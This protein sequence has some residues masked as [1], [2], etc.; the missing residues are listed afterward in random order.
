M[1]AKNRLMAIGAHTMNT[2][3]HDESKDRRPST[4]L[5]KQGVFD[6][7][8]SSFREWV[9]DSLG[10]RFRAEAGRYH[11]YV[12][13]GCPWAHRTLIVRALKGLERTIDITAVLKCNLR[14]LI[15]Y[16]NLFAD[17]R[18]F[19]QWPG[20]RLP[21][22][23]QAENTLSAAAPGLDNGVLIEGRFYSEINTPVF[24]RRTV[25]VLACAAALTATLGL[26]AAADAHAANYYNIVNT[27]TGRA[28][29][30]TVS[31]RVKLAPRDPKNLLQQWKQ[32]DRLNFGP[33]YEVAVQNRLLGCLRSDSDGSSGIAPLKVGNCAGSSSDSRKRWSHLSGAV[34]ASP[35]IP[36]AQM[37]NSQSAEYIGEEFCF[38]TC[39]PTPLAT[40]WGASVIASDPAEAGGFVKWRY[41]FA[42]SAP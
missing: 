11:L 21:T 37:V 40:L 23:S 42:T 27:Q 35:S 10:A 25:A 7:K 2:T 5:T 6:P 1:N 34:T 26:G 31:G 4:T 18:E 38:I 32:T 17:T 19:F 30:A 41:R 15:D 36:G 12:M 14:R 29:E 24:A 13:Y 28:L 8:P 3:E 9:R 20:L 16:L 33:F 39:G 22:A